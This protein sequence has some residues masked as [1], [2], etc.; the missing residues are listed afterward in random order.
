MAGVAGSFARHIRTSV[1]LRSAVNRVSAESTIGA[2]VTD[3]IAGVL[4][5]QDLLIVLAISSVGTR[6]AQ[7][8]LIADAVAHPLASAACAN[9]ATGLTVL[10]SRTLVRHK[11]SGGHDAIRVGVNL[12][13]HLARFSGRE[14][15]SH[16][17]LGHLFAEVSQI[18]GRDRDGGRAIVRLACR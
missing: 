12:L 4:A 1:D 2:F 6:S 16:G 14:D 9:A 11:L 5:R 3:P 7:N 15:A 10:E 17:S 18:I 13:E 8:R